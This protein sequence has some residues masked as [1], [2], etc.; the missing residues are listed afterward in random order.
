MAAIFIYYPFELIKTRMQTSQ[1]YYQYNNVMDAFYKM[2]E[3][4]ISGNE[5][6]AK[7]KRMF[8]RSYSGASSYAVMMIALMAIEFGLYETIIDQL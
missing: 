6:P 3:Q 8:D 5:S 4:P 2:W 1:F 7:L